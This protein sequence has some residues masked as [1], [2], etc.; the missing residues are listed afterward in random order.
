MSHEHEQAPV[1]WGLYDLRVLARECKVSNSEV[2]SFKR[3]NHEARGK[4]HGWFRDF[5]ERQVAPGALLS[6]VFNP[7][8]LAIAQGEGLAQFWRHRLNDL[9]VFIE[10]TRT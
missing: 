5:G 8:K 2:N 7:D 6:G 1:Q 4:A 10:T 9:R 3:V